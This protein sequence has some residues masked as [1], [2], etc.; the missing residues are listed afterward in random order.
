LGELSGLSK[1]TVIRA[2][3]NQVGRGGG[4][5]GGG[6]CLTLHDI[7]YYIGNHR[8][9]NSKK[10]RQNSPEK[11]DKHST[12]SLYSRGRPMLRVFAYLFA[13]LKL[14]LLGRWYPPAHVRDVSASD[15][16]EFK[17]FVVELTQ[18]V[19][20]VEKQANATHRKVY[21][22]STSEGQDA[23]IKELVGATKA[24]APPNSKPD[25]T[26]DFLARL[27]AGDEVPEGFL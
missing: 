2:E 26:G 21:R 13:A 7:V 24:P 27:G 11:L 14:L 25:N 20:E 16:A 4:G 15:Y 1:E 18:R 9:T 12:F 22:D 5:G 3:L 17:D 19:Y 23:G 10:K 6:E 8:H